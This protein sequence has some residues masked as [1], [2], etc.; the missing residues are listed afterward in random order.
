M[1]LDA[2]RLLFMMA[3]AY[4]EMRI[5][6]NGVP[7]MFRSTIYRFVPRGA[8]TS[9]DITKITFNAFDSDVEIILPEIANQFINT[10]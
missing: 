6:Y 9:V 3:Y 8:L 2:E 1:N 4:I 5:D 10:N 7:Q